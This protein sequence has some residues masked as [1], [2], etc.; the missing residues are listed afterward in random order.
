L[1]DFNQAATSTNRILWNV[2]LEVSGRLQ[3]NI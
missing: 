1:L 3:K 2:L